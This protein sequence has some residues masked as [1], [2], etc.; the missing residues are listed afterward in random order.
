MSSQLRGRSRQWTQ[1]TRFLAGVRSGDDAVLVIEG[2]PGSGRTR[3]ARCA[4]RTAREQGFTLV[5]AAGSTVPEAAGMPDEDGALVRN[6]QRASLTILDDMYGERAEHGELV[7]TALSLPRT[8]RHGLILTRQATRPDPHL[9]RLLCGRPDRVTRTELPPLDLEAVRNLVT[10]LVGCPPHP[11]FH[12]MLADAGGNP[13][14]LVELVAG[15]DQEGRLTMDGVSARPIDDAVPRRVQALVQ[16][17]VGRLPAQ[18]QQF[19]RVGV[20]LGRSFLLA[21]VVDMLGGTAATV[22]REVEDCLAC[23]ILVDTG[24]RLAFR[25]PLVWRSLRASLPTLLRQA[26]CRE[27]DLVRRSRPD[28]SD[29]PRHHEPRPVRRLGQTHVRRS[30]ASG[31]DQPG[32]ALPP[33]ADRNVDA[34]R[35]LLTGGHLDA[36]VT[37]SRTVLERPSGAAADSE[38]RCMMAEVL[39]MRGETAAGVAE[40][41]RVLADALTDDATARTASAVRTLG[42]YLHDARRAEEA[43]RAVLSRRDPAGGGVDALLAAAA[44]SSIEWANGRLAEGLR[45]GYAAVQ[46]DGRNP[47]PMWPRM[48]LATK[49]AEL[50]EFDEADSVIQQGSRE[51]DRLTVATQAASPAIARAALLVHAGRFAEAREEAEA[52]FELATSR[53]IRM[54]V[55]LALS[56]LALAAIRSGDLSSAASWLR[57]YRRQPVGFATRFRSVEYDWVDLLLVEAT[58][59]PTAIPQCRAARCWEL[60]GSRALYIREPGAAAWFVRLGQQTGDHGLASTAVRTAV[61][62]ATEN[63]GYPTLSA[64]AQHARGLFTGDAADV[65]SAASRHRDPWARSGAE[66]DLARLRAAG[67]VHGWPALPPTQAPAIP[68]HRRPLTSPGTEQRPSPERAAGFLPTPDGTAGPGHEAEPDAAVPPI[69]GWQSLTEAERRIAELVGEGLTNRQVARRVYLSPHTVNYHLRGIFR[70]LHI[71]SRVQLARDLHRFNMMPAS[72]TD[73]PG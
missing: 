27:A 3:L 36:A 32:P 6:P 44:I 53:G 5:G 34:V 59:G 26:L 49:L 1:V 7:R 54:L 12:P 29:E 15:L 8:S 55:P 13:R 58:Q 66:D 67:P 30:G 62:L 28:Q 31:P 17:E 25:Y 61:A 19:L 52:G 35:A 47:A 73:R 23:G 71:A 33:G 70:K 45:W 16:A 60:V 14:L 68:R 63:P 24:R 4:A 9:D 10:D 72:G 41:E 48:A 18:V 50:C 37:L 2:L 11:D 46:G 40:A 43:A 42:L 22:V 51:V 69:E 57:R 56:I 21:E 64:A 20:A 38:L 65:A 39:V